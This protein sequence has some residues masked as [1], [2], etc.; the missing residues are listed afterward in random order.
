MPVRLAA[1]LTLA[2]LAPAAAAGRT[3]RS[4]D[5]VAL[6]AAFAHDLCTRDDR[7]LRALNRALARWPQ[8]QAGHGRYSPKP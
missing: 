3:P 4:P 1:L 6:E 8:V 5:V 7:A 2:A